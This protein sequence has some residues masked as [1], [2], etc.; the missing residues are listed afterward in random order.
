MTWMRDTQAGGSANVVVEAYAGYKGEETPRA[1]IHEGFRHEVREIEGRWYTD[2]HSY[3]K[4]CAD[5][6]RRYVLRYDMDDLIWELVM[7]EADR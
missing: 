7:R 3:F 5:D 2:R 6:G 1:F 4:L